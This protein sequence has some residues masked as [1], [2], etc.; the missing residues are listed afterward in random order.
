MGNILFLPALKGYVGGWNYYLTVMKFSEVEKRIKF[1]REIYETDTLNQLIQRDVLPIRSKEIANYLLS[2]SQRFFNAIT[3]GVFGGHPEWV[4]TS[5]P[6][7]YV[8]KELPNIGLDQQGILGFLKLDGNELLFP[9]DGQHRVAGIRELN[10]IKD[11]RVN[12][13]MEEELPVIFV[14]H[15]RTP[16]GIRRIRRLFSSLN[17]YAKPVSLKD[18]I[19]LDEDDIVAICTR[20]LIETHPLFNKNNIALNTGTSINPN[21]TKS[22]TNVVTLYKCNDLIL[23]LAYDF[24]TTMG[25]NKYKLLRPPEE[26]IK[27]AAKFISDFWTKF[28][29]KNSIV[30]KYINQPG[31]PSV[32]DYRSRQGGYYFFRPVGLLAYCKCIKTIVKGGISL[33]KAFN[34]LSKINT[35]LNALPWKGIIWEPALGRMSVRDLNQKVVYQMILYMIGIDLKL[36]KQTEEKLLQE[37]ASLL[38][39][40]VSDVKLPAKVK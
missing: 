23:Q 12:K 37:Y 3:V 29:A 27:E 11:E 21:D 28:I 39:K 32:K 20:E 30:K 17:R 31:E 15:D 8:D 18:I 13:I 26:K 4:E 25:W 34:L 40:E 35:R 14:G 33:D 1:A 22:F 9:I 2:N 36:V 10:G 16:A 38:N 5:V 6:N 24:K 19:A 7:K